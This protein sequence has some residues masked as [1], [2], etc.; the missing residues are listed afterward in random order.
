MNI[1]CEKCGLN[2]QALGL[3]LTDGIL[4]RHA[5]GSR[6]ILRAF[7]AWAFAAK[8]WDAHAQEIER[9]QIL[10]DES[11][12]LYRADRSEFDRFAFRKN[13]GFG[14]Q[15]ILRRSHFKILG[16]GSKS[17]AGETATAARRG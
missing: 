3:S 7:D 10:D 14:E 11:G 17:N 13:L 16:P 4:I 15:F 9:V 6:H 2:H 1:T 8:F 12:T 5:R